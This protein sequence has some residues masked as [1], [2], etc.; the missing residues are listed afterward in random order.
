[1]A[2][3]GWGFSTCQ[4][5]ISEA[6]IGNEDPRQ[7]AIR[8]A[9]TKAE[10]ALDG[11]EKRGLLLSADTLVVDGEDVLG[12]PRDLD[13]ARDLLLRL[14]GKEH[15]VITAMI[16]QDLADGESFLEVCETAVPMREYTQKDLEVYLETQ[17]PMDKAGGYGIQDE[18]FHPV[19]TTELDGCYANVMGLPLCHV[20]RAMRTQTDAAIQHIPGACM[21]FTEYSCPVYED[22]LEG[23]M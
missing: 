4:V 3:T 17:S 9:R 20:A 12:K 23:R 14:K 18:S 8:L 11:V 1:M 22:V 10:A 6:R 16:L 7:M 13:H 21:Q 19:K 15:R 5:H 2:L